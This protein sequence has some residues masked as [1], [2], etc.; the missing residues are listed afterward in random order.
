MNGLTS[1]VHSVQ[2]VPYALFIFL[3]T[4]IGI[5]IYFTRSSQDNYHKKMAALPFDEEKINE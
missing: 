1:Q 3:I 5:V 4:F 2:F